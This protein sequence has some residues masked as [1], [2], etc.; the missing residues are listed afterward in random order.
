MNNFKK[1]LFLILRLFL[2]K[3][4]ICNKEVRKHIR[5]YFYYHEWS[6][7]HTI[8]KIETF[9][10]SKGLVIVIESHRPGLLIGRAGSF[11]DG[12]N[13]WLTDKLNRTDIELDVKECKLWQNLY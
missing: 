4:I 9:E 2:K 3:E 10:T 8:T 13:I 11:I 6:Y 7:E 12:L 1:V 5:G